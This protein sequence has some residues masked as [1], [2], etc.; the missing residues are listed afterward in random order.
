MDEPAANPVLVDVLRGGRIESMHRGSAAVVDRDGAL[1][2]AWG[3]VDR[4][5]FVRSAAKP[6][7]ALALVE[8]GAADASRV[9]A[10]ELAIACGSHSGEPTHVACVSD[11]LA[12][13]GL[14]PGAL[15]C[16]PHP[17]ANATAA[18]ALMRTGRPASALHNNCSGKHAGFLTAAKHLHL[19][20]QA[21]VEIGH[22]LQIQVRQIVGEMCG[23]D[24]DDDLTAVDGCSA[25]IFALPVRALAKAYARLADPVALAPVRA[26]AV[27][28]IC[29]AMATWPGMVA[30]HD[31]FDSE[32]IAIAAG[33]MI[34]KAGAEGVHAAAVPPLGLGIAVKIDDGA[35]RAAAAAMAALL[36]AFGS[37]SGNIRSRLLARRRESLHNAAGARIGEIRPHD[38]WLER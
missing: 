34:V 38:G 11:W 8:S 10:A 6:L 4:P 23:V 19:P 28:R 18:K 30:G 33:A 15:L 9:S 27:R 17:P 5:V 35:G 16:G 37:P 21:Y 3:N 24:I 7:Q 20:L 26:H 31:R 36:L 32:V 22:P 1:V 13:L 29:A 2:A 25:P 12:R 14:G